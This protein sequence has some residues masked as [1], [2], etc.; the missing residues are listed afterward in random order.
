MD[1]PTQ[2]PDRTKPAPATVESRPERDPHSV[3][4]QLSPYPKKRADRE[5]DRGDRPFSP[6]PRPGSNRAGGE[7]ALEKQG[8]PKLRPREGQEGGRKTRTPGKARRSAEDRAP[9]R[10]HDAPGGPL[11]G[12]TT[13]RWEQ[14]REQRRQP[15]GR[16]T[17]PKVERP[18]SRDEEPS[19]GEPRFGEVLLGQ[20]STPDGDVRGEP[21]ER[22]WRFGG[23][24]RTNPTHPEESSHEASWPRAIPRGNPRERPESG[25]CIARRAD[26]PENGSTP[27]R[28]SPPRG[29]RER[30]GWSDRA[31]DLAD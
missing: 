27:E 5:S 9:T 3:S 26:R 10:R 8:A 28:S 23:G 21:L 13:A 14:P 22:L 1:D 11:E 25:A 20:A 19:P 7:K 6:P 30:A 16:A 12:C 2:G 29:C 15:Q 17:F 31:R 18:S 4:P 24:I